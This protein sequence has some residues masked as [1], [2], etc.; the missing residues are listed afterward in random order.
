MTLRRRLML[1]S[2]LAVGVTVALA[3]LVCYLA[4][5]SELR[6][7]VDRRLRAQGELVQRIGALRGD[8]LPAPP[9]RAGGPAEFSQV[10]APDGDVRDRLGGVAI[11]VARDDRAAAGGGG[12]PFLSD[13]TAD[14]LHVRVIT[15]PIAGL[16]AVQLGRSLESVDAALGRLRIVL[17][18]LVVVGTAFAVAMARLFA[19]PVIRPISE[20]TRAAEHIEATGDLGRRIGARGEDEVGRMAQR[21]DAMLDR[22]QASQAAQRQLVADASHELRTPVTSLR[23]NME[24]LLAGGELEEGERRALLGDMVGQSEELSGLVGDLIELARGDDGDAPIEDVALHELVAEAVARARLRA[25]AVRF[26][27]E[28]APCVIAG[29]PDRLGRAVD[30]LLANAAAHSPPGGVVE[31]RLRDGLLE[32]RDHGPGAPEEELGQLFDHFFRGA[33]GRAQRGSGL[34]LAIVRQVADAHR[35]TVGAANAPGGGLVVR[36]AFAPAQPAAARLDVRVA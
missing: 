12:R 7:Q 2:A 3:S 8:E 19:R 25:G 5:R 13:R 30:N 35:A 27:A 10:V 36:L 34:G 26:C 33:R 29:L 23:T 20:L 18:L 4:M 6:T 11:A 21:F 28:L 32:V 31:V 17:A 24:V 14:G 9:R 1:M 22:V 15:V 16:G